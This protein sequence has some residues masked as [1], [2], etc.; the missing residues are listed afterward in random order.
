[1]TTLT[2]SPN[3]AKER[4][5][6]SLKA[7]VPCFIMGS[8]STA[9]S[10][11]VKQLCEEEGLYMIDIRLSQMLPM[12]LLGLPKVMEMPTSNGEAGAFS[13][14]IPFDTF[15]LEG[16]KIP[17]GYKGFCIFFDEA[18]QADKY[19]QGALYRIVLDRMV[20]TYKLHPETRIILAGNKLSD[21]AV[22]SKMSS[23]LKSRMTWINVDIDKKEFL[24]F[25]EDR[26][27][28]G[29]W[30]P[31]I[32]AFLNFRPELINN[33]NP[34]KDV[35]TYACGRTWEFLSK[36]LD[37]G[38]LDLGQEIYVPA[39]TGTIGEVASIE[40]TSFLQIMNSLPSIKQI[41]TD[42]LKAPLPSESG[43]KYALGAYLAEK[44]NNSNVNNI[45]EYLERIEEK[46]LL[47]L[48]YRMILSRYPQ[49]AANPKVLN[50]LGALRHKIN[51][52]RTNP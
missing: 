21:N 19:V 18:N 15:P 50:T 10:Y 3:Q 36:E 46:D 14:Y 35:E 51:N 44:V 39:I 48:A 11:T 22:A 1:M 6:V 45:V 32:L 2:L 29:E 49:I 23:A 5:R 4:L 37:N 42:P 41:E 8:P 34:K 28:K 16:C 17:D 38:L 43:A 7:N 24:Q 27:V 30:N 31:I 40:F 20:H 13:T 25:V 12:D 33:F 52:N 47:V 9:K 26:V